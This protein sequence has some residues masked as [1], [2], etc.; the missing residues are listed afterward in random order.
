MIAEGFMES[1]CSTLELKNLEVVHRNAELL[2]ISFG[3]QARG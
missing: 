3:D 1:A 2:Q